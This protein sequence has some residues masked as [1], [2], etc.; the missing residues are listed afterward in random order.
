MSS[1]PAAAMERDYLFSILEVNLELSIVVI[2]P[3]MGCDAS[4][5]V[6]DVCYLNGVTYRNNL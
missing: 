5:E 2:R 4:L 6:F 3:G 1:T